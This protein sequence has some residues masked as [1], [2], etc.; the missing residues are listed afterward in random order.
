ME[1][2]IFAILFLI[3]TVE[4]ASSTDNGFFLSAPGV[5]H[6]GVNEKVFVQMGKTHCNH[7]VT[8][9]L[10]HETE[11]V[12]MSEKKIT[13][14]T[15][16]EKFKTVELKIKREFVSMLPHPDRL[17]YLLL[18]AESPSFSPRKTTRVLISKHRGNIFIQTN[19]P[20]YNPT[21]KVIYRIFTLDHKFRPT[22]EAITISV[23]N[24][25]G[26][27][28]MKSQKSAKGGILKA[29]FPIPDVSKMGTWKITAHYE[30]DEENTASREFKVKK[31]VLPSFE[32]NIAMEQRYILLITEQFNFNILARYSHGE[33]VQGAYHCQFG[34]AKKVTTPGQKMKPVFIKRLELTGSVKNGAAAATLQIADL[35]NQL[36]IQQN[37]SLSELQQSGAQI[38]LGVFVTNIQSGEIQETEVYLPIISHKYTVDLSRTRTYFLPGYPLDVVAV[39]RH[40]DGSPAAG[41]P[42]KIDVTSEKP[43]QGTTDQEGAVFPVFNIQNEAQI[44]VMVTADGLQT[45][46]VIQKAFSPSNCF[47]YMSFTNRVYSVGETLTVNYNTIN[48][49]TQDSIYYMVF[50]RGSLIN[51]GSVSFGTSVRNNLQ[52]TSDMV[53]SF[54]LIGYYYNKNGHIIADSVWVDVMDECEIKAKVE[55]KGPFKPGKQSL[56]E[57]DFHGQKAKVA[58]LAVDKAIYALNVDNKLTAKQM[59]SSMQS[60]DLGC[61]YGG[62]ADPES[63]LIDAGLSFL[64]QSQAN[65]RK[66]ISCNS[67]AARQKRSVD[68]QQEMMSLKSNFSNEE[69]QGCCVQGFSLI[70]MTLTCME[71]VKRINLVKAKPGCKDAFLKC[72]LEG[73]RLRKKKMQ[74]D[75]QNELGRT[76]STDDIEEFFLDTAAQYIRRFFPPSFAF[77][78]FDVNGKG[79]YYLALPDSITT[80][81]I[82]VVTL[83]AATGFCVV[84][85]SEVRA[86]NSIFVSLRLPYSVKKYEQLM[87]SPI[88]YNY[89]DDKQHLAVHMEQTEGLCSA[90][91]ATMTAFVNITVEPQSTQSVSFSA[92]PMVTGQIP[93]KIRLYDIEND[94]GRDAIEKTLNVLTEGLETR[95]EETKVLKLDGRSTKTF[96]IDGSLPDDVVPDSVSNIFISVEGDGFGSSHA[97]NL[98]S[99]DK[100]A[101]LI[102]LPTGCLE[103][104][105]KNLAPTTSAL[106][107]L[108]LSDQWFDLPAGTR[109]DAIDKIEEGYVRILG[110]K[111]PNGAY[112]AWGS[113][114]SSNWV[115]ALVVKVLS[116]VAQRQT[117]A[118]GQQGR[119]ARVVP[120]GEIRKSVRYLLSVQK[121]DGSYHD[122]HPV[123]HKGLLEDQDDK[124]S[125]TAFINIALYRS[126]QF[127]N[128]E[129]K[130]KV[131]ASMSRSTSYL[132]THL[133]ELQHPY[134]VALT[135][136]CLAVCMPQGTIHSSAWAKLQT[137]A[138]EV[139]NGCYLWTAS[140]SPQNQKADTITV[141]TTAYAL[142]AAVE[143]GHTETADKTACWLT[144]QENYFGGY[145]SSQNTIMALEALAEY[146]IKRAARPETNLIAEF[147]AKGKRDVVKLTLNNKNERVETDL[148]KLAGNNINVKLTGTGDTKLKIV[149]AYHLLDSKDH[150]DKVSISVR[151]EGK[152]KYTA[153]ILENYDYY[154]DYSINEE[155]EARVTRSAIEWFDARTRNRRDLDNNVNSENTV[156]YFVCVS[157]SLDRNLTGMAVADITLLSGFQAET[158]GLDKLT[159]LPEQYI[160]HYEATYGRVVLYF[161]ELFE[162]KECISFD[163]QQIVPIGLL[164]PAP[165]V[166]YDYYEPDRTCTVF[167]SAPQRSTMTS[168]LCSADVCQC[169]ERPCHK[170]QNAFQRRPKMTKHVR[171]QFACFFPVVDYAYNVEILNVT[172]KSNFELYTVNVMEVLRSHGD[173]L[174]SE[175]SVR[176]FAKRCQCKG[177]LDLG[178]QYLIMGQDGA[179]TDSNGKMQYLLEANTWVERKPMKDTCKKS[180]YESACRE[181]YSFTEEYKL[182]GCRQ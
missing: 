39:V 59:F 172:T 141:E 92:V 147:T 170:M 151:V 102:A 114:P 113:V 41:V 50:S 85:P 103:Q 155:K 117:V 105:M 122:P 44:T 168:K 156:T 65:W 97:K 24:A 119:K 178:K 58:M 43:W 154:E 15:G 146:E 182:D 48:G 29:T 144:T 27:Q 26:N 161:N 115:T 8:L 72:C 53:P 160:A 71:R 75:A 116:L 70:P 150:C 158:Q 127:L 133:E 2:Y 126:L 11:L 157:H 121:T 104:T 128:N 109:D 88:I 5:F 93:I 82:Q 36:K 78:E 110:Y 130:D 22:E 135:A 107:Y 101:R 40:P 14:C 125:V 9:Y 73:E 35:R 90:G 30:N 61:T 52:I 171:F 67:Q 79:S 175:N 13:M 98:L 19:Q 174:V 123:L 69:F 108:D 173:I 38:Y 181:F 153:K 3:L 42:V 54:R 66:S 136:Y 68:L 149:K 89:G 64:S 77:T 145:T 20:I 163:A 132:L 143:L 164:Q 28:V 159:Q 165:A 74:E 55:S 23:I 134:A 6:V 87:I 7:P 99:P 140:A 63:V 34:V 169:A 47:L 76:S 57:F 138:T 31:F 96:T 131:N 46:K 166:F 179:T 51:Q 106:R 21:Q 100:V 17:K 137:L 4:S 16:T 177:L 33:K 94:M 60:Y 45:E 1:H 95:V 32:V 37:K 111:Q 81:E 80:W 62:G 139:E 49:P 120:E 10:E 25:A 112:S 118:F 142:L 162:S 83:S 152:V 124:A 148:K 12:V 180:A 176:V 18:V 167:Y 129:L 86:F 84:K 91:S 56:L